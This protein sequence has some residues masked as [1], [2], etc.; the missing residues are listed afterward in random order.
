MRTVPED[1]FTQ[2]ILHEVH[3]RAQAMNM[4]RQFGVKAPDVDFTSLNYRIEEVE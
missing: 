3:H 2:L 1:I 4:L